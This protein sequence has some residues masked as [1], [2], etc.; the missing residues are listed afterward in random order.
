MMP[1]SIL[2]LGRVRQGADR[3]TALNEARA[4]AQHAEQLG[5]GR[6]WVA[7]HHNSVGVTTAATSI[8]I[9]HIAAGTTKIRVGAGG[10]MLP[11][12]APY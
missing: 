5:Y 4:L 11:N 6:I 9:A 8:V 7:E 2:E 3:R 10:I 12:H 1:L